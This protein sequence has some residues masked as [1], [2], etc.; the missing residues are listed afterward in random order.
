MP[1]APVCSSAPPNETNLA[2]LSASELPRSQLACARRKVCHSR[3]ARP[4][5]SLPCEN[6]SHH[7]VINLR[8]RPTA[9]RGLPWMRRFGRIIAV[10]IRPRA[11]CLCNL[12]E[13]VPHLRHR[14]FRV[15]VIHSLSDRAN[16]HSRAGVIK[17]RC[18]NDGDAN[19]F[20]VPTEIKPPHALTPCT[21]PITT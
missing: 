9:G 12:Q 2:N 17:R 5:R 11:P 15:A 13:P 18:F 19:K 4:T 20:A 14:V 10:P 21:T 16:S 3:L 7:M 8:A 1:A 6:E